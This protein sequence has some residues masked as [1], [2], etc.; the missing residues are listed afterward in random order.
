VFCRVSRI[1]SGPL[2]CP[3]IPRQGLKVMAA[4]RVNLCEPALG[5]TPLG[6]RHGNGPNAGLV[7]RDHPQLRNIGR[8]A[9]WQSLRAS[10]LGRALA[11]DD[12]C[13]N[14]V[15]QRTADP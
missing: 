1:L 7:M 6:R 2:D 9:L 15:A 10:A 14:C 8:P 4:A 11:A 13:R 5:Q 3:G 12:F